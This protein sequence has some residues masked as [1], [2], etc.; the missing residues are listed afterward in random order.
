MNVNKDFLF[1]CG[2]GL[3]SNWLCPR[4][5]G[6]PRDR[7]GISENHSYSI[8][9]AKEIDGVRLLRLRYTKLPF[10]Q[11]KYLET[12]IIKGTPGERK[13]GAEPGAMDQSNGHHSGWRS[14]DTD[15]EMMEYEALLREGEMAML[16]C[17]AQVFWISYE[18]LLKKYQHFDRTRLFGNEWTIT[19]QWTTLNV[20]WSADYHSTKFMITVTKESPVVIVLSQVSFHPLMGHR[21]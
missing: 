12:N 5:Q 17:L 16:T 2:T 6:P 1:G 7:K 19:Q 14:W 15:L 21:M 8:M 11:F 4:Y 3:W 13:N 18:D 20:P 10:I 9:D